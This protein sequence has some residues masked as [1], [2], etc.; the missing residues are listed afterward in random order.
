MVE[1]GG[2][3]RRSKGFLLAHDYSC[4]SMEDSIRSGGGVM[5]QEGRSKYMY[6]ISKR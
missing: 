3:P 6:N 2:C 5:M 1:V 4:L